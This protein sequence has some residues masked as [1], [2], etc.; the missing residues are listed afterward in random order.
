MKTHKC[1]SQNK[2]QVGVTAIGMVLIELVTA[3]AVLGLLATSVVPI[4]QLSMQKSRAAQCLANRTSAEKADMLYSIDYSTVSPSF[5]SLVVTGYLNRIPACAS[6]GIYIW[7]T[8]EGS[9]PHRVLACSI[10]GYT[11]HGST[12][13]K[14]MYSNGFTDMSGLRALGPASTVQTPLW[15]TLNGKL[16]NPGSGEQRI[17]FGDASW[18]DYTLDVT[19]NLLDKR[20]YGIYYRSNGADNISGYCFQYDPG[21]GAFLVRKVTNGKESSPVASVRIPSA[22]PIYNSD[23]A[24]SISVAGNSHAI[25]IDGTQV[26]AFT[27]STYT[28]GGGG[29]R[30][31]DSAVTFDNLTVTKK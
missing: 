15:T 13:S 22:F 25:S 16:Y 19:A 5:A 1:S 7:Q 14:T 26:L 24:I 10:H 9:S 2:G 20:G 3:I 11:V 8:T 23:H 18:K 6:K 28:T 17:A 31:W 4:Y 21:A 27:D 12:S 29:F 30:S